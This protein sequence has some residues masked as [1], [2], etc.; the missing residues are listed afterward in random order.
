[1]VSQGIH[2]GKQGSSSAVAM[3]SQSRLKKNSAIER[4]SA[5]VQGISSSKHGIGTSSKVSSKMGQDSSKHMLQQRELSQQYLAENKAGGSSLSKHSLSYN[6]G[7]QYMQ[8]HH[9]SQMLTTA[10]GVDMGHGRSVDGGYAGQS[11]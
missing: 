10:S 1:M 9:Q 8:H 3:S 6:N 7:H 2:L 4:A 11:S 5:S